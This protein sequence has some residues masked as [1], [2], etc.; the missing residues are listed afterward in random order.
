MKKVNEIDIKNKILDLEEEMNSPFG[1]TPDYILKSQIEVL[2]ELLGEMT[3]KRA[4]YILKGITR[5]C[6]D[7]SIL[8]KE[9]ILDIIK[10]INFL[11]NEE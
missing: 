1:A 9:E 6:F 5:A 7:E 8:S 10:A 3:E 2:K 11:L 4:K